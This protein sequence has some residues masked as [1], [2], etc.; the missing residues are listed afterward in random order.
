MVDIPKVDISKI[1]NIKNKIYTPKKDMPK[2][3]AITVE[4]SMTFAKKNDKTYAELTEK[5]IEN[6]I[7]CIKNTIKLNIPILTFYITSER[8]KESENFT[9]IID[10]IV[11]MFKQLN[12][13]DKINKEQI[14][15]SVL[16]KWYDL[17]S[18]LV[19]EIK[20]IIDTTKDYDKF[21]VNFCIN[22]DGQEE[23]VDAVRIIARQIKA[24]KLDPDAI[25][26]EHIKENIY[27]SYFLPPDLIIKTGT[28][29]I[30]DSFLLWD[31]K[32]TT[33][34]FSDI[35]WPEFTKDVFAKGIEY[36]QSN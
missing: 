17:P 6:I 25:G 13:W 4:G 33:V 12:S 24:D 19:D 20:T 28:K 27:T 35:L 10:S 16:G 21:F 2:H 29:K 32:T 1:L 31:S 15:V 11:D 9:E 8:V 14:K 23:I 3:I 36:Y 30:L 18:R 34:F 22:Y 26:K 7:E 5:K